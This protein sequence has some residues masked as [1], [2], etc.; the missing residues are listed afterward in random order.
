MPYGI[1]S[2]RGC[3]QPVRADF[4][5]FFYAI[6]APGGSATVINDKVQDKGILRTVSVLLGYFL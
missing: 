3:M 4:L 5:T 2:D 1:R 6:Y